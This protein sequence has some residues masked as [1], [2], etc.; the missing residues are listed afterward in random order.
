MV[1]IV[2]LRVVA[3]LSC[4]G[5]QQQAVFSSRVCGQVEHVFVSRND[6]MD[7]LC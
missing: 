6:V 5:G 2:M 4:K 7:W 3:V 1:Q